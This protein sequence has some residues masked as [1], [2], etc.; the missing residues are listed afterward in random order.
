MHLLIVDAAYQTKITGI[1][2]ANY[3][4]TR[5]HPTSVLNGIDRYRLSLSGHVDRANRIP[6]SGERQFARQ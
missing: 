2:Y 1:I 3:S 5:I 4:Q 6:H